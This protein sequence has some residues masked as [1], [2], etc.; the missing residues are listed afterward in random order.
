[1]VDKHKSS[2]QTALSARNYLLCVFIAGLTSY[3]PIAGANL[4]TGLHFQLGMMIPFCIALAIFLPMTILTM[5]AWME[6]P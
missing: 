4:A 1:M 5:K 6:S 2:P 3:L